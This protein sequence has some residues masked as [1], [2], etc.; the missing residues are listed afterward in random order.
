MTARATVLLLLLGGA[1]CSSGTPTTGTTGGG[2]RFKVVGNDMSGYN[3]SIRVTVDG[4][5]RAGLSVLVNGDAMSDQGAGQYSGRLTTAVSSG[6]AVHLVVTDGSDTA[7]ADAPLP[8]TPTITSATI[9]SPGAPVVIGWTSVA[10]PDSFAVAVNYRLSDSSVSAVYTRVAGTA[11]QASLSLASVPTGAVIYSI[12][13][14][15]LVDGTFSGAAASGS[16]MNLR[17]IA[18]DYP[19]A[20]Q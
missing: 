8:P 9:A 2:T 19:F 13:L 10:S 17:A 3:E 7:T 1:A 15:A 5:G 12:S 18:A 4:A 14:D 11:R 20:G 6:G 16:T